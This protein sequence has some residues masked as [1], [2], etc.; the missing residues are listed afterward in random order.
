MS[1]F[2]ESLAGIRVD[3]KTGREVIPPKYNAA[4]SFSNG[5]ARVR[6]GDYGSKWGV[7]AITEV[8]GENS[9]ESQNTLNIASLWALNGITG[10]LEKGFV[11]TDLQDNYKSVITRAAFCRMAVKFVE[12]K[13]GK[14]IDTILAE[15]GASRDPGGNNFDPKGIYTREQ[16]I[17]TFDNIE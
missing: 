4:E 12:Y 6:L 7:I 14:M 16:S 5:L 11:P 2:N 1:S 13:T 15:K 10:A 17:L 8:S 3:D 9:K